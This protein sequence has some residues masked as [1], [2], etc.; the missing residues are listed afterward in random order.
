MYIYQNTYLNQPINRGISP[1]R[2]Y[3]KIQPAKET[4][5]DN[6]SLLKFPRVND[7]IHSISK[8]ISNLNLKYR[9]NKVL[10]NAIKSHST[11]RSDIQRN[12]YKNV[13]TMKKN[14]NILNKI[15]Q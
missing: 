4:S 11:V 5:K 3:S 6:F 2:Q 14:R 9:S 8:Q 7:Y 1:N 13:Y 15:N 12:I 10:P